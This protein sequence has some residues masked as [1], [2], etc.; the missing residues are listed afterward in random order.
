MLSA[1]LFTGC[2]SYRMGY[3][4]NLFGTHVFD[5][6]PALIVL[7]RLLAS[8]CRSLRIEVVN[9]SVDLIV[10]IEKEKGVLC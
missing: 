2:L 4:G 7:I 6:W 3:P 1:H 8:F 10:R 5:F 9:R